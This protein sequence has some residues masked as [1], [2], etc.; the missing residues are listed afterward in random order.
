MS[1]SRIDSLLAKLEKGHQKTREYFKRLSPDEWQGSIYG[2]PD[3]DARNL[4]AHYVSAEQ[5]LL[6]LAE[7]VA[8]KGPGAPEGFDLDRFNADEQDRLRGQTKQELFDALDYA[9][10]A[11]VNWAITLSDEQLDRKGKH[12]VLGEIS[13]EDMLTAIYGHQILHMRDITRR[14]KETPHPA[15]G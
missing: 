8:S 9:H 12:P 15:S 10:Q 11:T 7:N 2:D 13:V 1:P 3:W 5:H 4:L 14:R 6:E